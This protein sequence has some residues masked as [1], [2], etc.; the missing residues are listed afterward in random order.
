MIKGLLKNK[1]M[2]EYEKEQGRASYRTIVNHYIGDMVLCNEI[3]KKDSSV[4]DNM[5]LEDN[6][7]Y[8]NENDEEITEDEYYADDNA[9]CEN[10]TPEIY[11][12][13][14]CDVSSDYKEELKE[15]GLIFSYS[16]MLELD[17]L[18]VDH[19]GTGWDYV[20]TDCPLFDTWEELEEYN[21]GV[22]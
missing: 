1:D 11:Q 7:K 3:I 14:L 19:Y 22:K 6:T 2:G 12:Y 21:K 15:Y 4:Y 13:Y 18:C 8:Y 20:L 5:I 9:Y 10:N 16:D 17:V